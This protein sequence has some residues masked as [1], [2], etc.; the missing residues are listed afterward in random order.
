MLGTL[1]GKV[2]ILA[3]LETS[4][5]LVPLPLMRQNLLSLRLLLHLLSRHTILGER[6]VVGLLRLTEQIPT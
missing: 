3:T 1:P 4:T 5:R 6:C 2:A